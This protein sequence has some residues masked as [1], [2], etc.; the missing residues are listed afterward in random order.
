MLGLGSGK[1]TTKILNY[2]NI[3]LKLLTT[4]E[5]ESYHQSF[6]PTTFH[7]LPCLPHIPPHLLYLTPSPGFLKGCESAKTPVRAL[8]TTYAPS[9]RSLYGSRR[10]SLSPISSESNLLSPDP[11]T[12]SIVQTPSRRL[13]TPSSTHRPP[14]LRPSYSPS[15]YS[16]PPPPTSTKPHTPRPSNIH[17]FP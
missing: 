14:C 10:S 12:F 2:I 16:F 1:E 6:H 5:A 13:P 3:T 7:L 17:I 8:R 4:F 9:H 15:Q 11:P